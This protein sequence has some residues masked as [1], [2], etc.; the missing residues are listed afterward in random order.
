MKLSKTLIYLFLAPV[1]TG[2]QEIPVDTS[3]PR[4]Q[5]VTNLGSSSSSST[6][7]AHLIR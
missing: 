6:G 4:I 3:N 1:V 2:A 5:V 7:I